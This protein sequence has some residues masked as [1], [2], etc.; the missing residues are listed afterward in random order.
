MIYI[1]T[2]GLRSQH[3]HTQIRFDVGTFEG[4]DTSRKCIECL[5][6]LVPSE[7]KAETLIDDLA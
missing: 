2:E 6:Y 5:L 3:R 1:H 4:N 7:F